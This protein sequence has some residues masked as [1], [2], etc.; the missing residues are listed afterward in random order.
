MV[1]LSSKQV[2]F[3]CFQPKVIRQIIKFTCEVYRTVHIY[4]PLGT[5]NIKIFDGI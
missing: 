1:F 2:I 4:G 5:H 3:L